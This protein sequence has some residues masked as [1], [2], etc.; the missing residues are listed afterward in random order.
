MGWK[1]RTLGHNDPDIVFDTLLDAHIFLKQ[2]QG[3][4]DAEDHQNRQ[5]RTME[6]AKMPFLDF[7]DA[8]TENPE[9]FPDGT[10]TMTNSWSPRQNHKRGDH[11]L[12][13]D[14]TI[15]LYE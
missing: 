1:L 14:D 9:V 3:W 12:S 5:E 15:G 4:F 6:L 7:C 11:P 8:V 10:L 2:L 13:L